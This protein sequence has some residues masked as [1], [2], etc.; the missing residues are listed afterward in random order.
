MHSNIF[1]CSGKLGG[2]KIGKAS[3]LCNYWAETKNISENSKE[4]PLTGNWDASL[5]YL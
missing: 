5:G 2:S 4:F 1:L 3:Q